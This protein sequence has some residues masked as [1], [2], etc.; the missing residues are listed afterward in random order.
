MKFIDSVNIEVI[1]GKGGDG[2]ISFRH[3]HRVEKGGPFG[4][5]GGDGGSVYF[6]GDSGMNTLLPIHIM[7]HIRGNDGQNGM[8]KNMYGAKGED[9]IIKVPYGTLVYENDRLICDVVDDNKYLIAKGGKGGRGNSKFKSSTNPAPKICENGTPGEKKNVKLELKVMADIGLVG[10]PSAGKSTLLKLLSNAKPKIAD[11]PFTT[12][13]PQLGLVK[14]KDKSFVISDLPGLIEGA[15]QGKGLGIRFLKHIER[16]RVIAFVLDFGDE[17]KDP[18]TD[19]ETL[20]KE[21]SDFNEKLLEKSFLIIANKN[22]LPAFDKNYEKF[23]NKYPELKIISI[24]ALNYDDLDLLKSEM[25]KLYEESKDIP[26][27]NKVVNEVYVKLEDDFVITKLYEGMYEVSGKEIENVYLRNPLN[28]YE[29]ILRF[30]KKIKDMGLWKALIDKGIQ[31]GDTVRILGYQ[32]TW[33][34]D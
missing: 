18:I 31:E 20:K 28:T 19:F 34:N 8:T 11:Y 25:Y 6:Q 3:E 22:D 5:D 30:N 14:Y 26:I 12:L 16:C 32:F 21:L 13:V 23:T 1:A 2:I 29:N 4:G 24:C 27:M 17:N 10:L 33:E 9:V 15:S 7:K